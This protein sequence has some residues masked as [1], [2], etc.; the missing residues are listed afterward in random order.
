MVTSRYPQ[1]TLQPDVSFRPRFEHR[2]RRGVAAAGLTIGLVLVAIV[3][4]DA[5]N[6]YAVSA[7]G[8]LRAP[9]EPA[10]IAGH[11]GDRSAAPENTLPALQAVM[12]GGMD[13]VET[14][15]QLS[16]DGV[17]VLIHDW[18]VDRTTNGTGEVSSLTLAE[19]KSLDAGS[20][21]DSSFAGTTIPTFEEF[22][23]PFAHANKKA[24]LELKGFW[25]AADVRVVTGLVERYAVGDR[26]VF[27]SF[28]FTT[29]MN[30]DRVAPSLPTVIIRRDLS[31]DP[32]GLA[33]FF[34]AVAIL[35][36]PGSVEADS[37]LVDRMH[38]A[39]LGIMLYTLNNEERWSEA[40]DYGVD[41]IITDKPSSLDDW[42][43]TTAPGT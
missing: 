20:W 27:A 12:D 10:F 6:A 30:L 33:K 19:L 24:M 14:D 4:P 7:F 15:L 31:G 43:A 17:P 34:G 13:F 18:T 9:G 35:T 3:N 37:T 1:A 39:G 8:A 23:V 2:L 32:V 21:F 16:S 26:V 42:L 5:A 40:L 41:G 29:L 11:R 25:T 28:D 22:L 36:S 38:R